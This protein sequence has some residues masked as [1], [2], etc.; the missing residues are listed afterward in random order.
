VIASLILGIVALYY[1]PQTQGYVIDLAFQIQIGMNWLYEVLLSSY[2]LPVWLLLIISILATTTIL[3]FMISLTSSSNP[4]YTVYVKDSIYGANWRWKWSKD[5]IAN[6]QCYC[7]KCDAQLIYD[8]SSCHTRYTEV[9]KTD[10]ICENCDSKIVTSIHGGNKNYALGAIKREIERRI[11][12][13]EF[14]SVIEK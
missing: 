11:R 9:A 4:E 10:F 6:I 12:T 14:K 8:E 1:I 2:T 5:E 13:N 3:R 7:P